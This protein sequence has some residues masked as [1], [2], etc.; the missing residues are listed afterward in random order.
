MVEGSSTLYNVGGKEYTDTRQ[1]DDNRFS[2][3]QIKDPLNEEESPLRVPVNESQDS[4][5]PLQRR[6]VLFES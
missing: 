5:I 2:L 4:N 6:V 3:G 1:T